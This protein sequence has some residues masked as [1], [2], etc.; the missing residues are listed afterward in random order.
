MSNN[1]SNKVNENTNIEIQSDPEILKGVFANVT[2]IGHS[3]E[4]FIIDHLFIQQQPIPFGRLVS[5]I[6]LTPS[7]AKRLLHALE[8][9]IHKYE[10]N[11]GIIK[12]GEIKNPGKR[13]LQ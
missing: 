10:K 6:I 11:F 3:K 5:R 8:D 13:T 7:H 12:S 1:Q 4:E 2:N 9:N